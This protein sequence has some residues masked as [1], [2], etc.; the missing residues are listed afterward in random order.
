MEPKLKR[1]LGNIILAYFHPSQY[2]R[3]VGSESRWV[4]MKT[5]YRCLYRLSWIKPGKTEETDQE[6]VEGWDKSSYLGA[7]TVRQ[8]QSL[9]GS[10]SHVGKLLKFPCIQQMVWT[11]SV[12]SPAREKPAEKL[13]KVTALVG[14]D[15]N[16]GPETTP[17]SLS[18][19]LTQRQVLPNCL[20]LRSNH[21]EKA[22]RTQNR[23]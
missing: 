13:S 9:P 3:K 15:D 12:S 16:Q 2:K 5:N 21:P 19:T 1:P 14:V 20:N 11:G 10:P 17:T 8:A 4:W 22:K 18:I 7:E 23:P 6:D